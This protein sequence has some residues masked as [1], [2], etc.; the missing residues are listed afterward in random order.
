MVS[1]LS[2]LIEL[3]SGKTGIF[4]TRQAHPLLANQDVVRNGQ[5]FSLLRVIV[6][7]IARSTVVELCPLGLLVTLCREVHSAPT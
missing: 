1:V 2:C 5:L 6:S 3:T 4:L 7:S